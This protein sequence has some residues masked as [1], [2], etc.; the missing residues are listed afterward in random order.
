MGLI[1]SLLSVPFMALFF[2]VWIAASLFRPVL[3][4][5]ILA[6]LYN[7]IATLR[8]TNLFITALRYLIG[9]HDKKWKE[10]SEDPLSFFKDN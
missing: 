6:C 5:C 8:K 7:P 10:P 9:C 2:L 1:G 3:L 4:A